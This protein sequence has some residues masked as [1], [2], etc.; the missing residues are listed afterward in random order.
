[1]WLVD[2]LDVIKLYS[3]ILRFW[4]LNYLLTFGLCSLV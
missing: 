1:V 4:C 2:E 3:E